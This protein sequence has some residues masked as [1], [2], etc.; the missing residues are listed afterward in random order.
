M[1]SMD[2]CNGNINS[3]KR[4][5]LHVTKSKN[6]DVAAMT[7]STKAQVIMFET[8]AMHVAVQKSQIH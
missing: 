7:V 8:A 4:H 6:Y 2:C 5:P 3:Y 1:S